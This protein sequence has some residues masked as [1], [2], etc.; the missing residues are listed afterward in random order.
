M[1]EMRKTY[2]GDGVF[3]AYDTDRQML[4]L[5]AGRID[6][7]DQT[8]YL[9]TEPLIQLARYIAPYVEHLTAGEPVRG[10]NAEANKS[11]I[12]KSEINP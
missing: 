10:R 12:D 11:E 6:H 5:T 1:P 8:I 3:I 7:A 2:L 4:V 9:D